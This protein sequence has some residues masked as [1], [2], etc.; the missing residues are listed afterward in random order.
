MSVGLNA[1][2]AR[3]KSR[4]DI[5]IYN[6]V[7]TIMLAV[8]TASAA[9]A[10]V[11][12]VADGTTMTE[13]SPTEVVTGTIA[14]PTIAV[15]DSIII[16]TTT[17][18]LGTTGTSLNAI[19]ADINDAGIT[20]VVA[21]KNAANNLVLT[22][23]GQPSVVWTYEIGAG[24]ANT[25]LGLTAGVSNITTPTS[26]NYFQTWQGTRTNRGESQQMDQVIAHFQNMGFKIERTT[27]TTSQNTYQWNLYW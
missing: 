24:T 5:T 12:Y 22:F 14:N 2:Q 7:S 6:E 4:E 16:G 10:F 25:A 8:I 23:T 9:G 21:S 15:S 1:S 27:N 26:V 11:A 20:G 17:V 18:V 19:I 3:S 13:S